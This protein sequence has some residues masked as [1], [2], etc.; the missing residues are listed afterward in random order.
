MHDSVSKFSS[1]ILGH[2]TRSKDLTEL[3]PIKMCVELKRERYFH[4]Y[5]DFRVCDTATHL[6]GYFTN[7]LIVY[8][9]FYGL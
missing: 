4:D 1:T 8:Y 9:V 2:R 5:Y 6:T 3:R 7:L